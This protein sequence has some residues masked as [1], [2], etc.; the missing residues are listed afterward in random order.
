MTF[1]LQRPSR[2]TVRALIVDDQIII[3]NLL[4]ALLTKSGLNVVGESNSGEKALLMAEQLKPE[5][6]CLD[7]T[8]PG[9]SGLETLKRLKQSHPQT[10]IV[11][12]TG[13]QG[14]GDVEGAIAA[15][16]DGYIVKPFKVNTLLTTLEKIMHNN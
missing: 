1:M 16:A 13:H 10:K 2:R 7:I 5:L 8:M 11:M 9:I 3:R 15:G 12:I 6:I 14:K 4:R